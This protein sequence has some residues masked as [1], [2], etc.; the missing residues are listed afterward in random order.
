[1]VN[2]G[3]RRKPAIDKLLSQNNVMAV[4]KSMVCGAIC[5]VSTACRSGTITLVKDR[6]DG[7]DAPPALGGAAERSVDAAHPRPLRAAGDCGPDLGITEDVAGAHDHRR[8]LAD[9]ADGERS[10]QQHAER[11]AP[12]AHQR[13]E[14]AA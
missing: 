9:Q 2:D 14:C 8:L 3:R 11:A 7:V 10:E 6:L 13:Q 12:G 5:T 4:T 1:M